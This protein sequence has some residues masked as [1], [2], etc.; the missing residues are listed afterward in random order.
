MNN[1]LKIVAI[2][3][4]VVLGILPLGVDKIIIEQ[5]I[6]E[7]QVTLL[8]NGMKLTIKDKTGY[9]NTKRNYLFEIND[10]KKFEK[11]I[12][13]SYDL[14][15]DT[16]QGKLSSIDG[17][18]LKGIITNSNLLLSDPTISVQVEK[19]P[20]SIQE[21]LQNNKSFAEFFKQFGFTIWVGEERSIK[22]LVLFDLNM[23]EKDLYIKSKDINYQSSK[24]KFHI[25]IDDLTLEYTMDGL[26]QE[27]IYKGI[28]FTFANTGKDKYTM[29]SNMKEGISNEIYDF[30]IAG[31]T[32]YLANQAKNQGQECGDI[33][34]LETTVNDIFN[35]E[36]HIIKVEVLQTQNNDPQAITQTY[37]NIDFKKIAEKNQFTITAL[38]EER[39][40]LYRIYYDNN[41][42]ALPN[43]YTTVIN[44]NTKS[45]IDLGNNKL[46]INSKGSYDKVSVKMKEFDFAT[47]KISSSATIQDIN[48]EPFSFLYKNKDKFDEWK[49]MGFIPLIGKAQEFINGGGKISIDMDVTNLY[50]KNKETKEEVNIAKTD[51]VFNTKFDKNDLSMLT[52]QTNYGKFLDITS[53]LTIDKKSYDKTIEKYP[54]LKQADDYAVTKNNSIIFD[55]K[56]DF[57]NPNPEFYINNKKIN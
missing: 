50:I 5:K 52:F 46:N 15:K 9:F 10:L 43:L 55:M 24:N 38:E 12:T 11:F 44:E 30:D 3:M 7:E 48:T 37:A 35:S 20:T 31:Y 41:G 28:N 56:A 51:L 22:K 2:I 54:H 33:N 40:I 4:V 14:N 21:I 49:N 1:N 32:N 45:T 25:N 23:K 39:G 13:K 57:T 26:K 27:I 18:V 29:S 6:K 53:K 42:F 34:C 17:L 47:N 16:L 19:V 36:K 8:E